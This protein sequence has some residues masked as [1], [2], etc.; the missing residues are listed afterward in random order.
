MKD[1]NNDQEI[2]DM[3][4]RTQLYEEKEEAKKQANQ[5]IV[6][7]FKLSLK[8]GIIKELQKKEL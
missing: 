1:L 6:E 4:I 3:L 5:D 7:M 8:M 2:H